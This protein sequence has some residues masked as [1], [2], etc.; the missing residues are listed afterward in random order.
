MFLGGQP[1]TIGYGGKDTSTDTQFNIY[2]RRSMPQTCNEQS[3]L[4]CRQNI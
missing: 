4:F 1:F 3:T 2:M